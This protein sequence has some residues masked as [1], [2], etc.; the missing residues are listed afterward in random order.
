MSLWTVVVQD[1]TEVEQAVV[2]GL[3][4][5]LGYVDNVVVSDVIPALEDALKA[6][7]EKLGQEAVAKILGDATTSS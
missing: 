2:G 1:A 6:A 4:T 5:A 7:I 3:K